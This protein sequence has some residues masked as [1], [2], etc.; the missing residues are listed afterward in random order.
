MINRTG[1]TYRNGLSLS[2][3]ENLLTP[4]YAL[5]KIHKLPQCTFR[6]RTYKRNGDISIKG[7]PTP[8]SLCLEK[9][10][11][12]NLSKQARKLEKT[13]KHI[14]HAI[15]YNFHEKFFNTNEERLHIEPPLPKINEEDL[16][17]LQDT[18][19]LLRNAFIHVSEGSFNEEEVIL[20]LE[21]ACK[22]LRTEID[23]NEKETLLHLH[24]DYIELSSTYNH[25]RRKALLTAIANHFP[26]ELRES[27]N[28]SFIWHIDTDLL[29]LKHD[30]S[31]DETR[32]QEIHHGLELISYRSSLDFFDRLKEVVNRLKA[33]WR[34]IL[35]EN[36]E[37]SEISTE[38]RLKKAV[39][40]YYINK[41]IQES[42]TQETNEK[43]SIFSEKAVNVAYEIIIDVAKGAYVPSNEFK[44]I[45]SYLEKVNS[46]PFINDNTKLSTLKN[47]HLRFLQIVNSSDLSKDIALQ[48]S[49][50]LEFYR[51]PKTIL[52][53]TLLKSI[54]KDI[55]DL[56]IDRSAHSW[57]IRIDRNLHKIPF[58][59]LLDTVSG[60]AA[61]LLKQKQSH[62]AI[63][64]K[65]HKKVKDAIFLPGDLRQPG[66]PA[67]EIVSES[68]QGML[69]IDAMNT[70]RDSP[71]IVKRL[72]SHEYT[73]KDLDQVKVSIITEKYNGPLDRENG[74]SFPA[75]ALIAHQLFSGL[76]EMHAKG[77]IHGDIK[78]GNV[79][80][81]V[82][83]SSQ[84]EVAII[85]FERSHHGLNIGLYNN[86]GT[87]DY[88]SPDYII[89]SIYDWRFYAK[90]TDIWAAALTMTEI[91]RLTTEPLEVARKN[92]L[93]KL[94]D[95]DSYK[96]YSQ[97]I[98]NAT[99][100]EKSVKKKAAEY[101]KEI[102]A[103]FAS[104]M[105]QLLSQCHDK[106]SLLE[107]EFISC[108]ARILVC[109]Q[110]NHLTAEIL[111]KR[112]QSLHA[113]V[114]HK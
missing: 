75:A 91:T 67:V 102:C 37:I 113:Q 54:A 72:I 108:L 59:M 44:T 36:V 93:S 24:D 61:I 42:P 18:Y 114:I 106:R 40:E 90:N 48:L 4:D 92:F 32:I 20:Q 19:S 84:I 97:A 41:N 80:Q 47:I 14:S 110:K 74:Y 46:L 89:G 28:D 31:L 21:S 51:M 29:L 65:E 79:L 95:D 35:S 98:Y 101:M 81:R 27:T 15:Y 76:H 1:S 6:G 7:T 112:F 49:I 107:Y 53:A 86:Y 5:N 55:S 11:E 68:P 78:P 26:E 50:F 83:K 38:E 69:E 103:H 70:F 13:S 62:K 9:L 111:S 25:D 60:N 88:T 99:P 3:T 104:S 66:K 82:M 56:H 45:L 22:A 96:T 64:D 109:D 17:V 73:T 87:P 57:Q 63:S 94:H 77:I 2:K 12:R 16:H 58:S 30:E 85:D 39:C 33:I 52:R 105:I 8:P 100:C 10:H 23:Y 71:Y 43:P 34:N